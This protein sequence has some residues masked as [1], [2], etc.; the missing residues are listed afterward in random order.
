MV[1]V[2][3]TGCSHS[4]RNMSPTNCGVKNALLCNVI[5][6]GSGRPSGRSLPRNR[7]IGDPNPAFLTIDNGIGQPTF[8]AA[9]HTVL[10]Y[11]TTQFLI[12]RQRR[13][14]ST[15]SMIE[16]GNPHFD[17]SSHAHPIGIRQIETGKKGL[18]I[19]IL[20]PARRRADRPASVTL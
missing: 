9:F 5:R 6:P 7:W 3:D 16:I 19:Q 17:R 15:N 8:H 1:A 11:P 4:A 13:D 18:E 14:L 2:I 12:C 10:A 20:Q